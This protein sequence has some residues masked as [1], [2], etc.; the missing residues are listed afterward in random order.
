MR[1]WTLA[2]LF[3]GAGGLYAA[4]GGL[5]FL[6]QRQMLFPRFLVGSAPENLALPESVDRVWIQT[7]FGPVETYLM[8]PDTDV[9]A[10]PFPMVLFAHGNGERIDLWPETLSPF[11]DLGVGV[12]MVEY[13]G[14]GRSSGSPSQKT[15]TEVF[16]RAYDY[17][18]SRGDVDSKRIVLVGRSLGGGAVCALAAER[19]AR[20]L[21]L[22]STFT[23]VRSFA[24]RYLMPAMLVRDPFDNLSVVRSYEGP[25]LVIHG[26]RDETIPY[27]HGVTLYENA[28]TATKITYSAGHND[29]PPDWDVFFRDVEKFLRTFRILP[30][31]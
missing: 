26:D 14:Y 12:F 18:A 23:S 2:K 20:A 29:C 3:L 1:T 9:S 7:S 27:D 24:R 25:V 28:R 17:L 16:I 6:A 8:L 4:F 15:V 10:K 5:L 11:L 30:A 19:Q 13:P 22:M 21:I 31:S